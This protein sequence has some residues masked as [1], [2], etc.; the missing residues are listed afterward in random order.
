MLRRR[1]QEPLKSGELPPPRVAWLHPLELARTAYHAWLSTEAMPYLDRREML[2]ALD[3]DPDK[4]NVFPRRPPSKDGVWIDFVADVGDSWEATHAVATLMARD[5]LKVHGRDTPLPHADLVVIGGDL[6][7]PTPTRDGYRRRTREPFGSAFP[8]PDGPRRRHLVAI[9][10]NHDWYDGL[11]SFVREF[12]QGGWLGG[13]ELL[14]SRSYF[15]IKILEGGW[16]VW[17]IDIALD[18]RIDPAQQDYFLDILMNRSGYPPFNP[19]DRVI[20]CTAKPSWLHSRYS[21]DAYQNLEFLVREFIGQHGGVVAM[22]LSGD[23]HH[24]SRYSSDQGHQFITS[25]SGGAYLMGTHHLPLQVQPFK[26]PRKPAPEEEDADPHA[27]QNAYLHSAFVRSDFTYPSQED[28]RR[29][30]LG[31]LRL[32]FRRANIPFCVTV[33][34]I[35]LWMTRMIDRVAPTLLDQPY[36]ARAAVRLHFDFL[37]LLSILVILGGCGWFAAACNK[38][39][40]AWRTW[41]WGVMHGAAQLA[42]IGMLAFLLMPNPLHLLGAAGP[43]YLDLGSVFEP[44]TKAL[45]LLGDST[46]FVLIAGWIS[47]TLV[48]VYLTVSDR[49]LRWHHNEAFA[50]QSI[51]DYRSFLRI[52]VSGDGRRARIYPIG[53]RHVPRGWRS[54]A[55]RRPSDPQYEPTDAE[56]LP[57]LIEGPIDIMVDQVS[58][59]AAISTPLGAA[60]RSAIVR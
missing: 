21:D 46:V 28:S 36:G 58:T 54:R 3:T 24:Y 33:G 55:D 38:K 13:W 45:T 27:A 11:N 14:Q 53:L 18:T 22:M 35:A 8:Q 49:V 29:L 47:A 10:G 1:P 32:A 16:W 43:P 25:G 57:H 59:T 40:S 6:I 4:K 60:S 5:E 42:L 19:G 2:A 26:E 20:L 52:H 31:A 41:T 39:A 56:L 23:L 30:A 51:P 15:A 7:Y 50:V 17:G 9:P 48:G 37:A 44:V 12:C 34:V